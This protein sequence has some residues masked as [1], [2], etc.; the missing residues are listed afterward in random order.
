MPHYPTVPYEHWDRAQEMR[1]SPT[2][3]EKILWRVL[4]TDRQSATF[5]RQHPI[6]PYIVDFVCISAKL[7]VELDGDVHA[8]P[9]QI[10]YDKQ[11]SDYLQALGFRVR[12]YSNLDVLKSADGVILD[13]MNALKQ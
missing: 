8:R 4:R 5:R 10:E 11:R 7:I 12:R 1:R 9:E 3:A 2:R 6:G 13:I